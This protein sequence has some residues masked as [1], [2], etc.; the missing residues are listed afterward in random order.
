MNNIQLSL[1]DISQLFKY[2]FKHTGEEIHIPEA[3]QFNKPG[4]YNTTWESELYRKAHVNIIDALDTRGLWMMHCCIYP[5]YHNPAPIFGFDVFAGKNK[6]TGCFHDF[7]PV[8]DGHPLSYW[9]SHESAKLSWNKKREL[10]D[11]AKRIFSDDI[12]AAGNVSSDDELSQISGM[13]ANTLNAYLGSIK[14]TN[15]TVD[16]ISFHH[17]HYI[18]NQRLNPHNPNVLTLLGL[19]NQEANMYIDNC[20]FPY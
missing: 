15:N 11:W 13:I 8:T 2:N 19:S 6:I 17:H 18:E 14:D 9:F 1:I 7:S 12:V 20:L 16:D 5:H 10:P 4:W 3:D